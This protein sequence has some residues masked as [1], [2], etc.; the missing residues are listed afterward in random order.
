MMASLSIVTTASSIISSERETPV[1][2][3]ARESL[4]RQSAAKPSSKKSPLDFPLAKSWR[5]RSFRML[6][7]TSSMNPSSS[8]IIFN[9]LGPKSSAKELIPLYCD[10]VGRSRL[11]WRRVGVPPSERSEAK[12][13]ADCA[14]RLSCSLETP[15]SAP[16][17]PWI[18]IGDKAHP[19]S[20]LVVSSLA[21]GSCMQCP[22]IVRGRRF[23]SLHY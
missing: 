11:L 17:L 18:G 14:T 23:F 22:P 2:F 6:M 8:S 10:F 20:E 21:C 4:S 5:K 16:S 3:S 13:G 7:F 19:L 15:F 12:C 9:R 1:S